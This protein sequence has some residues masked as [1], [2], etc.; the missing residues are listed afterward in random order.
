M[1]NSEN[2][3]KFCELD[4]VIYYIEDDCIPSEILFYLDRSTEKIFDTKDIIEKQT[5]RVFNDKFEDPKSYYL[6][7]QMFIYTYDKFVDKMLFNQIHK[8]DINNMKIPDKSVCVVYYEP[9]TKIKKVFW[10]KKEY[11]EIFYK[12]I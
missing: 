10:R 4:V 5:N 3:N 8:L 12:F 1:N 11:E 6:Q 7:P 9:K 2:F